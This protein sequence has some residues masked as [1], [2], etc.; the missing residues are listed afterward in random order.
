MVGVDVFGDSL[1]GLL[2]GSL[3]RH[4]AS[5]SQLQYRDRCGGATPPLRYLAA[6][7][8]IAA[9]RRWAGWCP[10]RRG[11]LEMLLRRLAGAECA[12]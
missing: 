8:R 11:A 2:A 4:P 9:A 7:F 12:E 3:P 1:V 10:A 6:V 5:V